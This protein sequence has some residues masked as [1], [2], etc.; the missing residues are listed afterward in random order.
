MTA[1]QDHLQ[2]L[3]LDTI[4]AVSDGKVEDH[5]LANLLKQLV[6][7]VPTGR[8]LRDGVDL[9][10]DLLYRD[11]DELRAAADRK[12]YRALALQEELEEE[13]GDPEGRAK[14]VSRLRRKIENLLEDATDLRERA[15]AR[16]ADEADEAD[17]GF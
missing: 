6:G 3:L 11:A 13:M 14:R 7:L 2:R 10:V 15:A 8:L 16:E 4:E 9:V 17:V 1:K 5:E 12:A